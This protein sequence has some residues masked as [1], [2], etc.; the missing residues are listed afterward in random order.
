[1]NTQT[2]VKSAAAFWMS[3]A[4][5]FP[6]TPLFC[7]AVATWYSVLATVAVNWDSDFQYNFLSPAIL[8]RHRHVPSNYVS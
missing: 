8:S 4:S 1:M 3:E 7:Q 6:D 5:G 2:P